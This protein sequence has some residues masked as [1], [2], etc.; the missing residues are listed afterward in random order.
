VH[1]YIEACVSFVLFGIFFSFVAVW[2]VFGSFYV[3]EAAAQVQ[4]QADFGHQ[5]HD[6]ALSDYLQLCVKLFA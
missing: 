3:E 5:Q 2:T 4:P 1:Y 6:D